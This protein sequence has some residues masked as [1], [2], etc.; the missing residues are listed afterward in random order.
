MSKTFT[1][2]N[3]APK[4]KTLGWTT[5]IKVRSFLVNLNILAKDPPHPCD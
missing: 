4:Q 3:P 1:D 5:I 2:E